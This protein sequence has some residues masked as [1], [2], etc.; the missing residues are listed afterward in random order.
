[1]NVLFNSN[2]IRK[3]A[4]VKNNKGCNYCGE[5]SNETINKNNLYSKPT[6]LLKNNVK[7]NVKNNSKI[8]YIFPTLK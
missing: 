7:N 1:M 5:E 3:E 4:I 6:A 8:V 2:K